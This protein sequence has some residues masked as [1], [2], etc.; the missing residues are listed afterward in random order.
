MFVRGEKEVELGMPVSLCEANVGE[1]KRIIRLY[2]PTKVEIS[3]K[4]G[5]FEAEVLCTNS[6]KYIIRMPAMATGESPSWTISVEDVEALPDEVMTLTA[7]NNN[8]L[9]ITSKKARYFLVK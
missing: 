7:F 2:N 5:L 3:W 4:R 6:T 9:A 8:V 1:L